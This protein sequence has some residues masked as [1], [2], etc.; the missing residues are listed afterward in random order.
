ME[1]GD[2][3]AREHDPTSDRHALE[4]VGRLR[5]LRRRT[6]KAGLLHLLFPLLS[7]VIV[8]Q[9][10][11]PFLVALPA[12]RYVP[13]V[14]LDALPL[15]EAAV[16]PGA[17]ELTAVLLDLFRVF[18]A[19]ARLRVGLGPLR[20]DLVLHQPKQTKAAILA[21]LQSSETP[22]S[23]TPVSL[24]ERL[25][26]PQDR[27]AWERFVQLYTPLLYGWARRTGLDHNDTAD[28]LQDVF[29]TLVEQMPTFRYQRGGSFRGWLRT[30]LLNRWRELQR[31][32]QPL[33]A[34]PGT[35]E[36]VPQPQSPDLA[37]EAEE[38]A[39]LLARVRSSSSSPSSSRRP[40]RPSGRRW[41]SGGR[42]PSSPGRDAAELMSL[43]D[44]SQP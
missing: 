2:R 41:C 40:G 37:G 23:A 12:H 38:R 33:L 14:L 26:H 27:E 5:S 35:L 11:Q 32:K 10:V 8:Q 1:G 6:L 34:A 25:K 31:R 43:P 17:D 21:A 3:T 15:A 28:L 36:I 30:V 13:E 44:A 9:A 42:R 4:P 19:Q 20:R 7:V 18:D 16:L 39:E 29:A 24:L 22:M